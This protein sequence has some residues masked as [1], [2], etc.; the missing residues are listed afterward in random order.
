MKKGLVYKTSYRAFVANYLL[1]ALTI[2]FLIL[3]YSEFNLTFSF[4]PKNVKVLGSS[5]LFIFFLAIILI[6]IEE[7]LIKRI[8]Y[9]FIITKSEV[10]KIE[11]IFRKRQISI[12]FQSIADIRVDKS[13]VGRI[14]N[15]GDVIVTGFKESIVMFGL[16]KP[17]EL[18][19]I[20]QHKVSRIPR[21]F[22]VKG[23]K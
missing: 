16:N 17:D 21:T 18:Y 3:L 4:S 7:P 5:L 13:L 19:K 12:P 14:F 1:A 23:E 6:L 20:L 22:G 10:L 9:T 11:G 15:F 8:L 2:V